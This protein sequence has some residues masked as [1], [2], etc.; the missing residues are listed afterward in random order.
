LADT[1]ACPRCTKSTRCGNDC[2]ECELCPGK[3]VE[4]LPTSCTPPPGTGGAGSGGASGTSGGSTS[5]GRTGAGGTAGMTGAGGSGGTTYTCN[6]GEQVCGPGL[7][8]CPNAFYCSLGCCI[9]TIR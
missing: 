2:G 9:A 6:G 7:A 5:A 1:D 4:D 3:T 8:A